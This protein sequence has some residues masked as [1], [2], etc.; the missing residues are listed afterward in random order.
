MQTRRSILNWFLGTS[1]GAM[2]ASVFYPVIRYLVPPDIP[3]A[4]TSQ[5]VAGRDG[6]L[7][8]N[9]GKVFAFGGQ[10][11]LL[12]RDEDGGYQ[13]LSAT[14][15]HLNCTVQYRGDLKQ[16][17]CACHNGFYDRNGKNISG[18]PPRPLDS[19]KVHVVDGDV[20]VSK[21]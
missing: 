4:Q 20:V 17:W 13:A 8:P 15:T 18:P 7:K 11:A 12:I 21:S 6:D 2:C 1:A 9:E 19:Y 14:C 3:E 10:P 16:I 5:M